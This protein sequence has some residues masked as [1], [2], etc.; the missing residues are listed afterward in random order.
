[1]SIY[2]AIPARE[3]R[4]G[5]TSEILALVAGLALGGNLWEAHSAPATSVRLPAARGS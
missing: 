2:N 3:A 4:K 5:L 1:L